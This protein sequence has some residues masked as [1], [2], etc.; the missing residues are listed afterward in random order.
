[1]KTLLYPADFGIVTSAISEYAAKLASDVN[2]KMVLVSTGGRSKMAHAVYTQPGRNKNRDSLD[3]LHDLL[4]TY[5]HIPCA[6]DEL[7]SSG[8]VYKKLSL[9]ADKYDILLIGMKPGIE[10]QTNNLTD[11]DYS[12]LIHEALV[13][14][15][16]IPD[17]IEYKRI[18]QLVYAYDHKQEPNPPLLTL[19]WLADWFNAEV[20]FLSVLPTNISLK[21]RTRLNLSH[22]F[23]EHEW[24]STRKVSFETII[25]D[26][27][28]S[29]LE[30]YLQLN[31]GDQNEVMVL[32]VNHS[33][34]SERH[35]QKGV[36]KRL[37][38]N[39]LN[40]YII[41]HR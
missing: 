19:Y 29:A 40:P 32:S 38:K 7:I 10:G 8:N 37:L 11:I 23:V 35:W 4:T 36:L 14:I 16:L 12:K 33:T 34:V 21:E 30:G 9:L 2:A 20:K 17:K 1:M 26:D 31:E 41:I 13:P 39:A 3:K 5:Y 27:V 22:Q 6:A 18:H 24:N 25:N 28:T 15:F